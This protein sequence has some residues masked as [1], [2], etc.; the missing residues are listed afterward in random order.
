M[1]CAHAS[2]FT[3]YVFLLRQVSKEKNRF[4]KLMEY[5]ISDDCNIDFMVCW[6]VYTWHFNKVKGFSAV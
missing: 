5:F 3:K 2:L 4:E 1:I 6:R